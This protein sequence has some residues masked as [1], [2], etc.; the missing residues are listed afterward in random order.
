[1]MVNLY[2]FVFVKDPEA[3]IANHLPILM[4]SSQSNSS[5]LF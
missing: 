4:V 2:R 3:K 5:I 1:M